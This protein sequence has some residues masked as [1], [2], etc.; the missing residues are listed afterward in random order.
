MAVF[1]LLSLQFLVKEDAFKG[2]FI[3]LLIAYFFMRGNGIFNINTCR[4]WTASWIA[5]YCNFQLFR[6]GNKKYVFLALITPFIHISYWFYLILLLLVLFTGR[7]LRFW[8]IALFI[9]FAA[10]SIAVQFVSDLSVYLPA[11]L[12]GMVE[13]Y[14][15]DIDNRSNLYQVLRRVFNVIEHGFLV[16]V[17]YLFMRSESA[18]L[19][20]PKAKGVYE[21]LLVWLSIMF[22]VMPVPSLGHRYILLAMPMIAYLWLVTFEA[23]GLYRNVIKLFP[24]FFIFSIYEE[25]SVYVFW[26]VAPEF[27]L[28][29]PLYLAY[30]YLFVAIA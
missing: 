12:Q 1:Q 18:I 19:E 2:T 17:M 6:N 29:S 26:S 22:F 28:T 30:K 24:L 23:N 3:C 25:I 4:F 9:S 11:N 14:T 10:S 16:Y 5:I 21:F 20:N 7:F 15:N 8:K 13:M 27:W